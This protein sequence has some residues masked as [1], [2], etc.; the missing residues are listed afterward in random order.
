MEQDQARVKTAVRIWRRNCWPYMPSDVQP[1]YAFAPDTPWQRE[2]EEAF[3]SKKQ[4]IKLQAIQEVKRDMEKPQPMDRLLCGDV[5]YARPKCYGLPLRR[6]RTNKQ[7]AVLVPT[8]VVA[9][10]HYATFRERF[11]VLLLKWMF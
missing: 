8:T 4:Q 5:G 10:Q 1:G 6:Y 2:F 11:E 7:V 3:L 9:Q